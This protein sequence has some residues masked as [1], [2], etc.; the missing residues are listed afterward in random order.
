MRRNAEEG[1]LPISLLP[2]A[3][4]FWQ[5]WQMWLAKVWHLLRHAL[6][7]G[8]DFVCWAKPVQNVPFT[9]S[10]LPAS[11][12]LLYPLVVKGVRQPWSLQLPGEWT[13][14]GSSHPTLRYTLGEQIPKSGCSG[15]RR[16]HLTSTMFL[17]IQNHWASTPLRSLWVSS[18]VVTREVS[19]RT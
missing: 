5:K 9:R 15:S 13:W 3:H 2:I 6:L 7:M 8:R 14:V 11:G 4:S 12:L 16:L 18:P 17:C 19:H 10:V 1:V